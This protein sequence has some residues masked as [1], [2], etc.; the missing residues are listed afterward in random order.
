[1]PGIGLFQAPVVAPCLAAYAKKFLPLRP[2]IGKCRGQPKVGEAGATASEYQEQEWIPKA[3]IPA[4][5]PLGQIMPQ[6]RRSFVR[7][8]KYLLDHPSE[9]GVV[10]RLKRTPLWIVRMGW[11]QVA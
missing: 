8:C 1:M 6:S 10:G 11:R 5:L 9:G 3:Q 2:R 4:A 7:N